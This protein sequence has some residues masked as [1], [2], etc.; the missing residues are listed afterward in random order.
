MSAGAF[1]Q[2]SDQ[3]ATSKNKGLGESIR[4]RGRDARIT[5]RR[6]KREG[7]S[8][9]AGSSEAGCEFNTSGIILD[10]M[11]QIY[12][13]LSVMFQPNTHKGIYWYMW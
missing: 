10:Q 11:R 12:Q 7:F 3:G 6:E 5:M 8:V 2:T 1:T 4:G 9:L 13:Q